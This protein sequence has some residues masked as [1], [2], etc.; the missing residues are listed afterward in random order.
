MIG[1]AGR[2]KGDDVLVNVNLNT[3]DGVKVD[4]ESKVKQLFEKQIEKSVKDVLD[5]MNIKNAQVSLKDYGAL[6]FVIRARVTTAIRR[7]QGGV[8]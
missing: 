1:Q 2:E 7:A 4:I 8:N 6:D 5:E 3:S